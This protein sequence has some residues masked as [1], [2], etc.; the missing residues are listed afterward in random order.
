MVVCLIALP[1][2][3][4]LGIFSVSYRRL[5]WEAFDCVFRNVTFRPCKSGFDQKVKA[6]IV[7]KLIRHAPRTAG[8]IYRNFA[9]LSWIFV[10]LFFASIAGSGY[11]LYNYVLYG[12][13]NGP[14]SSAFC[15]FDPFHEAKQTVSLCG[16]KDVSGELKVPANLS[17]L[18]TTGKGV[19]VIEF[20]CFTCPYTKQVAGLTEKLIK[21]GNVEFVFAAFPL[22][23]HEMAYEANLAAEC[24]YHS[25]ESKY[26]D[27]IVKL[28]KHEGNLTEENILAYT[29]LNIADCVKNQT[30]KAD[31]EASIQLGRDSGIYGTPTFFVGEKAIV[32]PKETEVLKEIGK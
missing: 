24:V 23:Q 16:T 13:C 12:N 31:V 29:D 28:L 1:V 14:E 2:L 4:I 30:Y 18:P 20:G 25:D 11:G 26:W 5:A 21:D 3:V 17:G 19:R 9:V 22:Q 10:I 32:G 8:L 15:I 6:M 27:Y 7:G